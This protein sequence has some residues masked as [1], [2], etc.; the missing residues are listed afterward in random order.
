MRG[1]ATG[2]LRQFKVAGPVE[3]RPRFRLAGLIAMEEKHA[4]FRS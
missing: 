3:I 4:R 1:L 2:G